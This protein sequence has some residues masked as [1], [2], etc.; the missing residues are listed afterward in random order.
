MHETS[1]KGA[2][3]TI[4]NDS[5]GFVSG[6]NILFLACN[7]PWQCTKVVCTYPNLVSYMLTNSPKKKKLCV[8]WI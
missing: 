4:H 1:K 8:R 2:E 3:T 7:L 5:F 6:I